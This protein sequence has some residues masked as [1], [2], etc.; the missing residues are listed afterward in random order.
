MTT[1]PL[2]PFAQLIRSQRVASLGTVRTGA[3]LVSLVAYAVRPDLSAFFLHLSML[4]PHTQ[5][6]IHEARISLMIAQPDDDKSDPQ[7]LP[8]ISIQGYALPIAKPSPD[9]DA[10][11]AI[12]LARIPTAE[13]LFA[14]P[15]FDL[16]QLEPQSARF[17]AGFGQAY[18][19]DTGHFRKAGGLG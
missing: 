18:N 2:I 14:L 4:A 19:L 7:A 13:P 12:Y 5:A 9:Y 8:R 10:A 17:I 3:P 16:Y 1:A 6:L 15:D 11:R